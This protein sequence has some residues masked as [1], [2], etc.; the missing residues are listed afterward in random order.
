MLPWHA[1]IKLTRMAL[2]LRSFEAVVLSQ[3]GEGEIKLI[4]QALR[5]LHDLVRHLVARAHVVIEGAHIT[6]EVLPAAVRLN[7]AWRREG[8]WM[9]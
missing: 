4:Q 9:S 7:D 5:P 1:R 6:T 3:R 8:A 2:A